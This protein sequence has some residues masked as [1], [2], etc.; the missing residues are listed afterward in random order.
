MGGGAELRRRPE[1]SAA[2]SVFVVHGL[3][4]CTQGRRPRIITEGAAWMPGSRPGATSS[5]GSRLN[6]VISG[7]PIAAMADD[8]PLL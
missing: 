2:L 5:G 7:R 3:D 6:S 4:P 8:L 1:M